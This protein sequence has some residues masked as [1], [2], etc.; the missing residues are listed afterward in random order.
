MSRTGRPVRKVLVY[1]TSAKGLL[2]F[3][4]PDFP[5]ILPQVPGGTVEPSESLAAAAL[6]EF[7]EETG[8]TPTFPPAAIGTV[9][10][11]FT[12]EGPSQTHQRS[13][14]HVSLSD[15]LPAEWQ[16]VEQTPFDGTSPILF[17]FFWVPVREAKT[18]LGYGMGE[19][20]EKLPQNGT[21]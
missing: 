6:R 14:F 19:L 13:Y 5:D 20:L 18:T 15:D 16:H 1:A 4:E 17:R 7:E 21:A 12:A 3:D 8:L 10:Y 11:T 2:V 9:D